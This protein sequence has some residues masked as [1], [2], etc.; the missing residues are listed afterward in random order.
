M[1][2]FREGLA[3]PARVVSREGLARNEARRSGS[4]MSVIH[5]NLGSLDIGD[6]PV[7]VTDG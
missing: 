5:S 6:H 3:E 1:T 7:P 4:V 2:V